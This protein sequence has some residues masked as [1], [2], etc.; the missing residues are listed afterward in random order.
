MKPMFTRAFASLI[1]PIQ[2]QSENKTLLDPILEISTGAVYISGQRGR[3]GSE[4]SRLA[5][6]ANLSVVDDPSSRIH[7]VAKSWQESRDYIQG[8]SPDKTAIDMSG[9]LKREELGEYGLIL[10][11]QL[12]SGTELKLGQHYGNPGCMAL[13]ILLGLQKAGIKDSD[14]IYGPLSITVTGGS[15][16][17]SRESEGLLRTGKRW[18]NHPHVQEIQKAMP[19]LGIATF[20]PV[21]SY[22][23]DRGS[24]A[25]ISGRLSEKGFERVKSQ[26]DEIRESIDVESVLQT[27]HVAMRLDMNHDLYFTLAL[28]TDNLSLPSINAIL[29]ASA[30]LAQH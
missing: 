4:V 13:M 19:G 6:L 2:I 28:A 22:P 24:M 10:G 15:S 1:D 8:L 17:A 9:Y 20:V 5:K 7:I 29:L 30:L 27:G 18:Q 25:I 3:I 23:H 12:F 21:I 16:M 14:D 11:E 26:K